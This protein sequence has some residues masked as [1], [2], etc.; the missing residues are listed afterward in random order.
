VEYAVKLLLAVICGGAIGLEREATG[1][2]AGLRTNILISVGATLITIVSARVASETGDPG[3]IAAQIVTGVGFIGAG[4]IIQARGAITG[5]TTAATIWAVAGIGIALGA[6]LPILAVSGTIVILGCLT[7]LRRFDPDMIGG[8]KNFS[9]EI[10][11]QHSANV[12]D[13]LQSVANG[14]F[15]IEE[16]NLTK[17]DDELVVTVACSANR[18]RINEILALLCARDDVVAVR[19]LE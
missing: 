12:S 13:I 9:L 19:T 3:R 15:L 16:T 17:R 6:G 7:L 10:T 18:S 11:A 2:P 8:K 1:K 5:L 4:S 14:K